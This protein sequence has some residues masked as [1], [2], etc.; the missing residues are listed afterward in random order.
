MKKRCIAAVVAFLLFVSMVP[1]VLAADDTTLPVFVGI[2]INQTEFNVGDT[3]VI[4]VECY[5][6]ESGIDFSQC[7]VCFKSSL[8]WTYLQYVYGTETENGFQVRLTFDSSYGGT[9]K[10]YDVK[11]TDQR[12]NITYASGNISFS[13]NNAPYPQITNLK[14]SKTTANVGDTIT[15]TITGSDAT[16]IVAA[17]MT[18]VLPWS[19]P[20]TAYNIPMSPVPGST[21]SFSGSLLITADMPSGTYDPKDVYITGGSGLT[22]IGDPNDMKSLYGVTTLTVNSSVPTRRESPKLLSYSLSTHKL[23]TGETLTITAEIDTKGN[24]AKFGA[25]IKLKNPAQY[26]YKNYIYAQLEDAGDGLYRAEVFIPYDSKIGEYSLYMVAFDLQGNGL[27]LAVPDSFYRYEDEIPYFKNG[28]V[29]V[30]P[31]LSVEG[32]DNLSLLVGDS[33]DSMQGVTA[34]NAYTGDVTGKMTV[35][36]GDIDTSVPGLYLVKYVVSDEVDIGGVMNP[37]SYTDYRWIGVSE[38]I[39]ADSRTAIR[40]L[41]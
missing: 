37:I 23:V 11:I 15:Y 20:Y 33:F 4:D 34:A 21:V 17:G 14:V 16:G 8:E 25:G 1:N 38:I 41:R 13:V 10:I 9:Y 29:T 2:S 6:S 31:L 28:D 7:S 24:Q 5:D 22:T 19:S 40:R 18:L 35:L 26:T 36:D 32:T 3:M 39:P 12:G 30:D 27:E